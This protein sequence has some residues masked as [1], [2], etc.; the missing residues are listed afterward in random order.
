M[1]AISRSKVKI[2]VC[3]ADTNPSAL[4]YT[5]STDYAP[6][7]GEIQSYS[8]SGGETD[9]ESVP[10]FG[11]FVDKEKPQSQFELAFEIVPSLESDRWNSMAYTLKSNGVYIAGGELT[12]R[13][14]FIE[15][16][17]ATYRKA[18]GFN[19]CEISVLDLEHNADDNQTYN[20]TLKFSPTNSSNV[21]NVMTK[22]TTVAVFTAMSTL[23]NW[24]TLT[25]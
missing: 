16:S 15:A 2:W 11:G 17:D 4:V 8:K 13:A 25:V 18:W 12:G 3:P 5:G 19:N 20:M 6:I 22:A 23:P 24:Y 14:V 10:V 9:T 1:T 21:S 7:L